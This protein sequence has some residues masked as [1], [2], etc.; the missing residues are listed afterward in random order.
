LNT[1]V[2]RRILICSPSNQT[3][4]ELAWKLHNNAIGTNGI[5]GSFN[6][7][8]FGMLPGEARVSLLDCK[9]LSYV[10]LLTQVIT[11][12]MT[13]VGGQMGEIAGWGLSKPNVTN[14][15]MIST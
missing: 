4:D 13:D 12:S 9:M 5:V 2:T 11:Y 7:I 3:V 6:I 1:P 15:F 10:S 8:R 14:F